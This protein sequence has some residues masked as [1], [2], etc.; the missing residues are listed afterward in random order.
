MELHQMRY[1]LISPGLIAD[2]TRAGE[3]CNV[4]QPSFDPPYAVDLD[5]GS[6]HGRLCARQATSSS[7]IPGP[8]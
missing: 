7:E 4:T 2:F 5:F 3:Q 1:F 6:S 8:C